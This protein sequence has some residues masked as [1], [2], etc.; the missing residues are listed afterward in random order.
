MIIYD[1]YNELKRAEN[2]PFFGYLSYDDRNALLECFKGKIRVEVNINSFKQLRELLHIECLSLANVLNANSN[3][4]E[5][6][7]SQIINM[8]LLLSDELKIC[9]MP[10]KEYTQYLILQNCQW[11]IEKVRALLKSKYSPNTNMRKVLAPY[12]KLLLNMQKFEDK[13]RI[14]F[15][16][17]IDK[18]V[19]A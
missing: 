15:Q 13:D 5:Q 3:P 16:Q 2:K 6:L 9:S 1:K 19:E 7:I 18:I 14:Y 12:K 4:F 10:L 17:L 8:E 11:D